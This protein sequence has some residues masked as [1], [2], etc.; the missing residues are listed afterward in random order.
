MGP[1][2]QMEVRIAKSPERVWAGLTTGVGSWWRGQKGEDLGMVLEPRPGGRLYRDLGQDTGHFWGVVQVIKPPSLLEITGP[3]FFSAAVLS[4]LSFRI[5]EE[6]GGS[7]VRLTQSV[8][9]EVGE[10]FITHAEGGWR[11]VM[12]KGLKAYVE[13]H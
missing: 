1:V 5:R 13:Q 12:E 2:I 8:N 11:Q 9:G 6:G 7:V 4:H 3:L 10:D